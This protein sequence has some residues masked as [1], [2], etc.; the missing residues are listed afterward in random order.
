[1]RKAIEDTFLS[2]SLPAFLHIES[3][4]TRAF[5]ERGGARSFWQPFLNASLAAPVSCG[6]IPSP[7]V[8]DVDTPAAAA[9][10]STHAVFWN[11]DSSVTWIAQWKLLKDACGF[12]A[13]LS[14]FN[15]VK[16]RFD[17]SVTPAACMTVYRDNRKCTC[18]L[19]ST[20]FISNS[21]L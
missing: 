20:F 10:T 4:A 9:E 7:E 21:V 5:L 18:T 19:I 1:M 2:G 3:R 8:F 11:K 14:C 13:K 6:V 17:E 12:S 15:L 16:F